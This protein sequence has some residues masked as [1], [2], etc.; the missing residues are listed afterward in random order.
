M[1]NQGVPK[2]WIEIIKKGFEKAKAYVKTDVKGQPLK[3]EKG[4]RQGDPLSPNLF[5]CIL[6]E[7]F[8]K[9]DWDEKGRGIK[10]NGKLFNNL[11]F[12]DD[13]VLIGKTKE[14]LQIMLKS[15]VEQ[16][17][18]AG[19]ECN[20]EKTKLMSNG[21]GKGVVSIGEE[22]IEEVDN[23]NYLGER[24]PFEEEMEKELKERRKTAWNIGD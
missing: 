19:M 18:E 22:T 1:A 15:I 6:G 13:V 24:L 12:A 16:S 20:I 21:E 11:R 5:N 23:F 17:R 2:K 10:I 14:E 3:I 4:V 7:I 8:R 9:M